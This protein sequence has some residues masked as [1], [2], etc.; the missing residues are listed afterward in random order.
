MRISRILGASLL[1]G[2]GAVGLSW[3]TTPCA[4]ACSCAISS[5]EEKVGFADLVGEGTVIA[6]DAPSDVVSSTDGTVFTIELDRI[7]KGEATSI[8]EVQSPTSSASCGLDGLSEGME[9]VLFAGHTD[10]MGTPTPDQWQANLCGGTGPVDEQVSAELDQLLG[11]A[12]MPEPSTAAPVESQA[13]VP[14][15][16]LIPL[17]LTGGTSLL[18]GLFALLRQKR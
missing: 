8:V 16:A 10:I 5:T 17:A 13:G 3:G 15:G 1:A 2:A 6:V 14:G 9:I 7:W 12:R 11:A 18:A 4:S